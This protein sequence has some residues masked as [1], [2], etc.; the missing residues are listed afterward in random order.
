MENRGEEPKFGLL[1]RRDFAWI[2]MTAFGGSSMLLSG[3]G[4]FGGGT[5]DGGGAL[6]SIPGT[7]TLPSG[8]AASEL[9]VSSS[10][11]LK[12][13]S[14]TTYSTSVSAETP[15]LIMAMH[16]ATKKVVAMAMVDPDG[17]TANLNYTSTAI[18]L[19]YLGLGGAMFYGGSRQ[20]LLKKVAESSEVAGLATAIRTAQTADKFA[21][22][23]GSAAL[24]TKMQAAIRAVNAGLSRGVSESSSESRANGIPPMM[25]IEPAAAVDG[26]TVVQTSPNL[27]FQVQNERRRTATAFTYMVG[28]VAANGTE[29]T[30]NPPKRV[31]APLYVP[32]TKNILS[33]PYGWSQVTSSPVNISL[34]GA[35][36]T[37]KF[38]TVIISTAFKGSVPAFYSDPRYASQVQSWKDEAA[39]LRQAG[40]LQGMANLVLE[41]LGLGGTLFEYSTLSALI[42]QVLAKTTAIRAGLIAAA[43]GSI[44]YEFVLQELLADFT[45]E[46]LFALELPIIEP[47]IAQVSAVRAAELFAGQSSA[48]SIAVVRAGM[49]V[50]IALG[51]MEVAD[52]IAV[53]RDTRSGPEANLWK[54][55]AFQPSVQMTPPSGTYQPGS[56]QTISVSAPGVGAQGVTYQWTLTGSSLANISDG[57]QVGASFT[58][59]KS[60][61]TLATTP[62]TVGTLAL[63]AIVIKN[64]AEVG[65]ATANFTLATGP[66]IKFVEIPFGPRLDYPSGGGY[67]IAY[68]E[69]PL[70]A[71][72]R[73]KV[74]LKGVN[75][76]EGFDGARAEMVVSL[77]PKSTPV[78]P[79]NQEIVAA[80]N[81]NT[82]ELRKQGY[83][84]GEGWTVDFWTTSQAF[85]LV[86]YGDRVLLWRA[87]SK[88]QNNTNPDF[89]GPPGTPAEARA[90]IDAVLPQMPYT[91]EFLP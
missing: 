13:L 21:L 62:S 55:T 75:N 66:A 32:S 34:S 49:V 1:T 50:L 45:A 27:G 83:L 56:S 16:S 69:I 87:L 44:F 23:N 47:L 33:L 71:S 85:R 20:S 58:S 91:I 18:A 12:A 46:A 86:S 79:V 67:L 54:L 53:A 72:A 82:A 19:I 81:V 77:P 43:E 22:S 76:Q 31:G 11:G 74:K 29:T 4:G 65:R 61:V 51:V 35:D 37:T 60:V 3:C 40:I 7:I 10:E 90:I 84:T 59:T 8:V 42:P 64:G 39:R 17:G 78:Y 25:L 30:E 24:K 52:I 89:G 9:V 41:V 68:Q 88:W 38:E 15:T 80:Q 14:E 36:K 2:M 73:T 57:T 26:M 48:A 5:S 63:T 28:H 6:K 70:H